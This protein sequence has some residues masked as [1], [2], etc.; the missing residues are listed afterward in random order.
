MTNNEIVIRQ[1]NVADKNEL[2]KLMKDGLLSVLNYGSLSYSMAIV[3]ISEILDKNGK[4]IFFISNL[5]VFSTIY[6]LFLNFQLSKPILSSLIVFL[7]IWLILIYGLLKYSLYRYNL[8][9][10]HSIKTDYKDINEW[11]IDGKSNI[12]VACLNKTIIGSIGIC[13]YIDE[14]R[15][16]LSLKSKLSEKIIELKRM[17]VYKNFRGLG[18]ASKLLVTL[19]EWCR[20]NNYKQIILSTTSY[21]VEALNFYHKKGFNLLYKYSYS[22]FFAQ[23]HYLIKELE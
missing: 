10:D 15:M 20:K 19:E 6:L 9:Y 23:I 21:Q 12:W 2:H 16:P 13:Q 18:I 22:M 11:L 5:I 17:Y 8:Y 1:S 14:N 3:I 7:L 4:R